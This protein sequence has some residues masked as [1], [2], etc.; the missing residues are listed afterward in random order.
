MHAMLVER[1]ATAI[2]RT[3]VLWRGE[4]PEQERALRTRG[5]A[6]E[7]RWRSNAPLWAVH[8]EMT[9]RN[10]NTVVE[11]A[12]ELVRG[13]VLQRQGTPFYSF[14]TDRDEAKRYALTSYSGGRKEP[15]SSGL[16]LR[17]SLR[18]VVEYE[19]TFHT[20]EG[21]VPVQLQFDPRGRLWVAA[22]R[23]VSATSS[24]APDPDPFD[25]IT[26]EADEP[27]VDPGD[28]GE[29]DA[30]FSRGDEGLAQYRADRDAEYL[31]AGG[32]DASEFECFNIQRDA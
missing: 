5:L 13:H 6:L 8:P 20:I 7:D 9:S 3:L 19:E 18:L 12:V 4:A 24:I 27:E 25:E 21:P 28:R 22:W 29:A 14:T 16:L 26:G 10:L 31:V 2:D 11:S 23:F 17:L 1:T 15:R 32:I 30:L